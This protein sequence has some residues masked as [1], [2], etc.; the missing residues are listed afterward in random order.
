MSQN[1][2]I[3]VRTAVAPNF[4]TNITNRNHMFLKFLSFWACLLQAKWPQTEIHTHEKAKP[5]VIGRRK[6]TGPPQADRR[7]TT[8]V[9]KAGLPGHGGAAFFMKNLCILMESYGIFHGG[10]FVAE[11]AP[12][13]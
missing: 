3:F 9:L 10:I 2:T 8:R 7:V 5:R 1:L 13:V 12:G 4:H 11:P 6:A